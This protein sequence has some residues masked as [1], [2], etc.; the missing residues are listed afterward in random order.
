MPTMRELRQAHRATGE[1]LR[2]AEDQLGQAQDRT[3]ETHRVWSD[4]ERR[5]IREDVPQDEIAAARAAYE[6]AKT[7][8]RTIQRAL[9]PGDVES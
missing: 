7:D 2:A 8:L 4:L 3:H 9:K 5:S 6:A 1:A